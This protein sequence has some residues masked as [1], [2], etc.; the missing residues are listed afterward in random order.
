MFERLEKDAISI[1]QAALD[2]VKHFGAEV[3][4]TA[5]KMVEEAKKIETFLWGGM[6][7][8]EKPPTPFSTIEEAAGATLLRVKELA[9]N[10]PTDVAHKLLEAIPHFERFVADVN[11]ALAVPATGAQ[12]GPQSATAPASEASA[13]EV[14]APAPA[15]EPVPPPLP[16][17]PA[18]TSTETQPNG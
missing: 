9:R 10:A 7:P 12:Q 2:H 1:R 8:I 3:I 15:P 16:A 17:A 6:A 4:G 11:A 14:P 18:P 5:E 13:P